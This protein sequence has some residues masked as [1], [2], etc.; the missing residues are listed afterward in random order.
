MKTKIKTVIIM[1]IL[2]S[3]CPARAVMWTEGYHQM[4][5]GENYGESAIFN[6]VKLDIFGGD[7]SYVDA[8]N[9]TITNWYDG[10]MCYFNARDNSI[11]NI[12]GGEL[13]SCLGAGDNG[14]INLYHS[15]LIEGI[16]LHDNAI[17]NLHAYDVIHHTTGGFYSDGWIEGRYILDNHHFVIDMVGDSFSH[18]SIVPEPATLLLLGLGTMFVKRRK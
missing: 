11:V 17:L 16:S 3:A 10:E 6:D 9:S 14:V 2:F 4:V 8:F 15:S 5:A 1:L 18:I 12:Y 13:S 7:I